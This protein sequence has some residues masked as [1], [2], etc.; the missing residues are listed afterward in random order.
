MSF[1]KKHLSEES[2]KVERIVRTIVRGN[3]LLFVGKKVFY[4]V[5]WY[6]YRELTEEPESNEDIVKVAEKSW[7]RMVKNKTEDDSSS[8]SDDQD[9]EKEQERVTIKR[10]NL[11]RGS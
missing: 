9:E 7:K 1:E 3:G 5:K 11:E 2:Y 4:E 8:S 6:G 10:V